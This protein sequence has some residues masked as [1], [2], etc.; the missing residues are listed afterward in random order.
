ME[1]LEEIL[2][3]HNLLTCHLPH[4][5]EADIIN[6]SIS[7]S[8][9]LNVG[10]ETTEEDVEPEEKT[11]K[12]YDLFQDGG[13]YYS[14]GSD[15]LWIN[16]LGEGEIWVAEIDDIIK[17]LLQVKKIAEKYGGQSV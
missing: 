7:C 15:H 4:N 13:V 12:L 5:N 6:Q 2:K 9:E 16:S 8:T 1:T 11:Y 10:L 14:V 3:R 17:I